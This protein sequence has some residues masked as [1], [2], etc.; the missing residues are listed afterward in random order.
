MC[1]CGRYTSVLTDA[2]LR[3]RTSSCGC[4]KKE[5]LSNKQSTHRQ[6]NTKLYSIWCAMKSRCNNPNTV[7]YADY[8]GRGIKVCTEWA[9]SFETFMKWSFENG[10]RETLSIDRIDNNGNYD[11]YNC[12]W[13]DCAAQANNRRSNRKFTYNGETHNINEW[14]KL[15]DIPY[16]KLHQRLSSGWD[17]ARALTT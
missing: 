15:Y 12:R 10:Y 9:N 1:E 8:G 16:K 11:P 2:L 17:I 4:L 7:A 14:A 13:V 6:T 5:M 3:G